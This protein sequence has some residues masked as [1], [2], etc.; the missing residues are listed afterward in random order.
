MPLLVLQARIQGGDAKWSQV[1]R[2]VMTSQDFPD[3]P[4]VPVVM[5]LF[6]ESYLGFF[7]KITDLWG[8]LDWAEWLPGARLAA[9]EA[10]AYDRM[11]A[12]QGR[13][14]P[15][16]YGFCKCLLPNGQATFGHVMEVIDGPTASTMTAD[17]LGLDEVG[18]FNLGDA[19][20]A[21]L[22]EMHECGVIH[23]D[24]KGDNV[25]IH[26]NPSNHDCNVVLLDFALCTTLGPPSEQ[27][28]IALGDMASATDVFSATRNQTTYP[29]L[30]L[31]M[32]V[33]FGEEL[34]ELDQAGWLEPMEP[35][36]TTFEANWE[37]L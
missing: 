5:K 35:P 9:N 15:W 21:A 11:R 22:H 10:W 13:S 2:G 27:T 12:L 24:I 19:L 20:A 32:D 23:D 33:P 25:I 4:P 29:G 34:A 3:V 36:S 18:I 1:W 28:E 26:H 7:P 17:Q 37:N 31:Q 6:Q 30:R 14:V 16:S 8:N